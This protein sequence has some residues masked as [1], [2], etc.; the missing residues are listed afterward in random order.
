MQLR[1]NVIGGVGGGRLL[2]DPAQLWAA[3]SDDVDLNHGGLGNK[4][5]CGRDDHSREAQVTGH[6]SQV[7]AK[8]RQR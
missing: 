8:G 2:Q 1:G 6:K 3:C 7:G 4:R 5:V